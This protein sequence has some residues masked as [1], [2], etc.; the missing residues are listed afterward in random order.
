MDV[1]AQ[2]LTNGVRLA[3]DSG[4]GSRQ[5]PSSIVLCL[6]CFLRFTPIY[7]LQWFCE[8]KRANKWPFPLVLA[9]EAGRS[10]ISLIRSCPTSP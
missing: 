3:W 2:S 10:H 6:S 7:P 9:Q 8:P 4:R 1:K 5:P